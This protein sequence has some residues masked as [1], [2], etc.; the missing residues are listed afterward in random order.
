MRSLESQNQ[1][2]DCL[3]MQMESIPVD[4]SETDQK[5]LDIYLS[6]NFNEQWEPLLGGR[7]KYGLQSG[8]LKL[9]LENCEI[10]LTS[11]QLKGSFHLSDPRVE[12]KLK[13]LNLAE[14]PTPIS[15]TACEVYPQITEGNLS[16]LFEVKTGESVLRGFLK[17]TQLGTLKLW[18]NSGRLSSTF[19]LSAPDIHLT[20]AEGLWRHDIIPNQHAILERVIV[21][22]LLETKLKPYLSYSQLSSDNF[23]FSPPRHPISTQS[24]SSLKEHI[25]K[26]LQAKT[27][28][29]LE[30]ATLANL[31]YR[32]DFAG[33]VLRGSELRGIDFTG[34]NLSRANLRGANLCDA[35]LSEANLCHGKLGGADLSGAF[36]GDA[37]LSYAD[38]HRASLA[39]TNLSG[40]NLTGANLHEVNLVNANL[41]GALVAGAKFGKNSGIPEDLKH[42]LIEKGAIF[43]E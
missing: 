10:S 7:V 20:D 27:H 12:E 29:F 42:H 6:L 21:S 25:E 36:L 5:L 26:I 43:E 40:A 13:F 1:Y 18:D 9:N 17:N 39:L 23:S 8:T 35:D 33:G 28:D 16:W 2:P 11:S 38:F 41:H 4:S 19:E 32:V 14:K 34:A 22:Y 24:E 15:L 3:W 30:L 31:N 37:D